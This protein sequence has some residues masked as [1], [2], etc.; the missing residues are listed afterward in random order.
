MTCV[1]P[2]KK[3]HT[4][5][6]I[7]HTVKCKNPFY[8][9]LDSKNKTNLTERCESCLPMFWMVDFN[10]LCLLLNYNDWQWCMKQTDH[11]FALNFRVLSVFN[12]SKNITA[13]QIWMK[14]NVIN[15]WYCLLWLKLAY[16]TGG[17]MKL[18]KA[19][20]YLCWTNWCFNC[21][22][23]GEMFLLWNVILLYPR[24]WITILR[25][26]SLCVFSTDQFN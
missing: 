14:K 24:K 11:M 6:I 22:V 20:P 9:T 17:K 25:P 19:V 13:C 8:S 15:F 4:F 23:R 10:L 21:E 2:G 16:W 7:R 12:P 18:L 5:C 1:P 26:G 3:H